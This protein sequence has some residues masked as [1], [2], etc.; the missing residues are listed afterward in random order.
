MVSTITPI[1]SPSLA[2]RANLLANTPQVSNFSACASRTTPRLFT[3]SRL[4]ERLWLLLSG[5][6]RS[7]TSCVAMLLAIA[8]EFGEGELVEPQKQTLFSRQFDF[9]RARVRVARPTL[10]P[11]SRTCFPLRVSSFTNSFPI[12]P[13]APSMVCMRIVFQLFV[14]FRIRGLSARS[15][16]VGA[17]TAAIK[18]VTA[19]IPRA[20][21][22]LNNSAAKPINGGPMRKPK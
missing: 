22:R 9:D 5:C 12:A 6:P 17:S 2:E 10:R 14:R 19:M 16:S 3:P 21:R 20:K 7:V 4:L 11:T 13:P 18:L 1:K 8:L 15:P